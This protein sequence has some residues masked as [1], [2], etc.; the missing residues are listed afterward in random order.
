MTTTRTQPSADPALD[1]DIT[2]DDPTAFT[3]WRMEALQLLR[4]GGFHGHTEVNVAPGT[5]LLSGASGSG[6]STLLDAYIAV[7]ME[8]G[9]AFNGASN[10]ATIGRARGADQRSLLSYLR[11]K[12]DTNRD[13]ST[14]ELEDQVLRGRDA[15]TW[16]AL[17]VTFINDNAQRYTVARLFYVPRSATKDSDLV[18]KMCTIEGSIDLREMEPFAEGKFDKRAVE[19]RFPH[20]KIYETY[21]GFS[22][23]FGTR[24]G[25]GP[26]GEPGKALRLLA[27]IQAG[28]QVRT[29]DDLYKSLVLERPATYAAADHAILHF[30]DLEDSYDAM[31]AEARKAEVLSGIPALWEDRE[32]ARERVRLIDTFGLGQ[33]HGDTVFGVWKLATEDRLLEADEDSNR[34]KRALAQERVREV[35]SRHGELERR[36]IEVEADLSQNEAH[37]TLARLDTDIKRLDADQK[38]AAMQRAVFDQIT[39]RLGLTIA[40]IEDFA[41]AQTASRTFLSAFEATDDELTR[42]RDEIKAQNYA[43]MNEKRDLISERDSLKGRDGRMDPRL[44]E[45]R[46]RMAEAAGIPADRLPFVGELIDVR[47]GE[48][49]WRKAIETTLFGLARIMLVDAADLNRL[50]RSIDSV[51]LGVRVN[52]EGIDLAT[53]RPA[54]MDPSYVSGKLDYKDSDFTQWVR[55][56]ITS[57]NTDALCVDTPADLTGPGHRVTIN[58]QTRRGRSG[59]HG[60]SRAPYV[61]GF[62][63]EERLAEIAERLTELDTLMDA[64]ERQVRAI[65]E[66][67]ATLVADRSAHEHVVAA[68][69]RSIDSDGIQSEIDDLEQQRQRILD[70]DD[71]LRTLQTELDNLNAALKEVG[72]EV[73]GARTRL[74]DLQTEQDAIVRRKDAVVG[75]LER[76]DRDQRIVLTEHQTAYLDEVYAQVATVGD[77]AQFTDGTR[78][79][80][81]RL[82]EQLRGANEKVA[83]KTRALEATF[84]RFLDNWPDPNL[85]PAVENYPTFRGIHDN[86]I[87][88]GLADRRQEWSKR[89]TDWSGQDLVP[90]AGAFSMAI[91]EIQHRLA[92]I[93]SILARLPFGPHND[94]LRIDLRELHRDDLRKFRRELNK[95][96][97]ASTVDFSEREIDNWFKA[98]RR[99][100]T[101]IREDANG[102]STKRDYFLDVNRHIEITAVAFDPTTGL[103]RSTYAALGGKSGGE[104]QELIAFIVGAAL[105]FQ[106]GDDSDT[107][108]R[109]APVILDEGFI[110]SDGEFTGRAVG[111]WK[112][113]GFQLLIGAP[114]GQVNALERHADRILYMTK[115]TKGYSYLHAVEPIN[116]PAAEQQVI[117][118]AARNAQ[119]PAK[120]TARTKKATSGATSEDT[121]HS[122]DTADDGEDADGEQES[123]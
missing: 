3:Q 60:T 83:D 111:A 24:L 72:G 100:M 58:G 102:R 80:K 103:D 1:I 63:N 44:H 4:W 77:R 40:S 87:S 121:T 117:E 37:A 70:S 15:A 91:E 114:H 66:E 45:A 55:E 22:A 115:S 107:P 64:V 9:T 89:L 19:G 93:N 123:A 46:Q 34:E 109:F 61:I 82:G 118:E 71:T 69:W 18:R 6:K 51:P 96:S 90:L 59:A 35:E 108:P 116:D 112:G 7:M 88:K 52:F 16:G 29:V 50:S 67:K 95:L 10:D 39:A 73:Y 92:P 120:R 17:A 21:A 25:I 2:V 47:P 8:S 27:R 79:L 119:A 101:L 33:P 28:Q 113:L 104:T 54:P 30:K 86:I 53:Y 106:L 78:R 13:A 14:G 62:S 48:Q 43:P 85:S 65:D 23:A 26:H 11:G 68:T 42:R 12:V 122:P 76:I 49:K 84:K 81:E 98:L 5:S 57:D 105:R 32:A 110:K 99:F 20:L 94:R 74:S 75:E 38:T 31:D 56:R 36:K 41:A 97:G